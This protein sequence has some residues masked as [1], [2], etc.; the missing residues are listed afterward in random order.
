MLNQRLPNQGFISTDQIKNEPKLFG[1]SKIRNIL[2]FR[3]NKVSIFSSQLQQNTKT[4]KRKKTKTKTKTKEKEKKEEVS[5][6]LELTKG[7]D[8]T[9]TT[10]REMIFVIVLCNAHDHLITWVK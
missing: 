6:Y 8:L 2:K 7:R 9:S 10:N 5:I 4:K 3:I 1:Q